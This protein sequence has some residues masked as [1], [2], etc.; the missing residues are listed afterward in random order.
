MLFL[1]K[2]TCFSSLNPQDAHILAVHFKSSAF[3][4][5][6]CW[7]LEGFE[8]QRPNCKQV[9]PLCSPFTKRA[10][11]THSCLFCSGKD[12]RHLMPAYLAFFWHSLLSRQTINTV[13]TSLAGQFSDECRQP[14]QSLR[15][16]ASKGCV[17][18]PSPAM[19]TQ[20]DAGGRIP[21]AAANGAKLL[22]HSSIVW[23]I[24]AM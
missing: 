10:N 9:F 24:K 5:I 11:F 8:E 17:G 16:E 20:G 1:W 3:N 15:G 12:P 18:G 7:F 2:G 19:K 21:A 22:Y 6:S 13:M 23:I 4:L 14:G